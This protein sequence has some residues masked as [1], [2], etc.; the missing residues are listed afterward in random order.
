MT[1][2]RFWDLIA[3]LQVHE[4][5]DSNT[6]YA[7]LRD[8]LKTYPPSEIARFTRSLSRRPMLWI[9]ADTTHH[10]AS[11][12]AFPTRSCIRDLP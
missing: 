1:E 6:D 3:S 9:H 4:W 12:P 10:T 2:A 7:P 11:F 5:D 8:G